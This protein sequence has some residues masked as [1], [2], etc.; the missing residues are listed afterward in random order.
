MSKYADTN[1]LEKLHPGEPFFFIRARDIFS[2]AVIQAYAA[3]SHQ[4]R[5]LHPVLD[6]FVAWQNAN[7]SLVKEPD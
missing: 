4:H 3:I 6:E 7:P 2:P 1:P 5:E